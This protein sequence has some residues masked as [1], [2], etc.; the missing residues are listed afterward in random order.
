M[1]P[2]RNLSFCILITLLARVP[3]LMAQDIKE[4]VLDLSQSALSGE[5]E[6]P[7]TGE[8]GFRWDS[9]VL[10]DEPSFSDFFLFPAVWNGSTSR[11][12]VQLS[13]FGQATY[14]LKVL[15]PDS[16]PPL[17]LSIKHVYSSG[18][19]WV[20]GDHYPFG[21]VPGLSKENEWPKWVP[22]I[23]PLEDGQDTLE[24]ILQLSNHHHSTGG[25]REP[26]LLGTRD[27]L[28]Q[29]ANE[30]LGYDLLLCGCLIMTSLFFFG[31]YLFGFRRKAS[32][33]FGAFCL[34]F[35][36]RVLLADDYSFQVLYPKINWLLAI[37][38]EYLTLF[39]PPIFFAFYT[40]GLYRFRYSVNPFYVFITIL[41][42]CSLMVLVTPPVFFT[43]F[44]PVYLGLL[45]SGIILAIITY[46]R[47]YYHRMEGSPYALLSTL[48]LMLVF[49]YKI[50]IYVGV[51]PEAEALSFLGFISFFFFQS[52]IL[53]FIYT[54]SLRQAKEEAEKAGQAKS[55]FLSM[56]SH[57]IRTPMN[58]VIGL[59]NYILDDHPKERHV[60]SLNT[61]RF[62]AEHLLVIIN[63]IL[64]FSKIEAQKIAFDLTLVNIRDF[65]S[66][67]QRIFLPVAKEKNLQLKFMVG[68]AVPEN[69]YFDKTRMAQILTNLLS[70][71]IK[72]TSKGSVSLTVKLL[73]TKEEMA[74]V[75][76]EVVDTGIGIP[77]DRQSAIFQSFTQASSST[78]R[79]YGGTGL[80]LTITKKLLDLQGV[81]LRM[82]SSPGTGTT[83]YFDQSLKIGDASKHGNGVIGGKNESEDLS[84]VNVLLV[85][86][87]VINVMVANKFLTRWKANVDVAKNGQEAIDRIKAKTYDVVLMDLQM[88]V[89]DGYEASKKLRKFKYTVPI[90]ALTASAMAHE[91]AKIYNA[92][93][94]AYVLKPFSPE[95]LL[96]EITRFVK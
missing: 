85:E 52:L 72:F 64:D 28:Q 90:I 25:A 88:P 14:R 3:V 58:A 16:A 57:E 29:S 69:L 81:E 84:G 92:G 36:F 78:T 41:G 19:L 23:I 75:R 45:L 42:V 55:D 17:A 65:V 31:L 24:I 18:A 9:L 63:D 91:Q 79:E 60:E 62:S 82:A 56:M 73:S 34:F 80:G 49:L 86:D 95:D 83:F 96:K 76:F 54:N 38:L 4:G 6:L 7:L 48:A 27:H 68:E 22:T 33:Y 47:A 30:A 26:F 70:N 1:L 2:W 15:L 61:L 35:S 13:N 74:I 66:N 5:F 67:T 59:T 94:D 40:N 43:R 39:I 8:W 20:N 32:M 71:A 37:K 46:I 53:F 87:N 51:I 21:G 77:E 50:V 12:G 93:M 89:M 11:S 44:V 10:P